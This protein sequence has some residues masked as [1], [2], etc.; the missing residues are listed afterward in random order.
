MECF[1]EAVDITYDSSTRKTFGSRWE[2]VAFPITK[3][4]RAACSIAVFLHSASKVRK[5]KVSHTHRK[6]PYRELANL[7]E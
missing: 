5:N 4:R 7:A 3:G 6:G 2:L 1:T